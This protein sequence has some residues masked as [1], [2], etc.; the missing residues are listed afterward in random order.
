[1]EP[2]LLLQVRG[3]VDSNTSNEYVVGIEISKEEAIRIKQVIESCLES[4]R[5]EDELQLQKSRER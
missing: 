1:V 2:W 4:D 3:K 5:K